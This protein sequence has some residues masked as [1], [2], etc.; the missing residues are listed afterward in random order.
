MKRAT[1]RILMLT[2]ALLPLTAVVV[3]DESAPG[4]QS[5][6]SETEMCSVDVHQVDA[7]AIQFPVQT[8]FAAAE[9]QEGSCT[10]CTTHAQCDAVCG[11]FGIC[12]RDLGTVCG[13]FPQDKYCFC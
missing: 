11:G 8:R 13:P 7:S 4:A 10:P 6:I 9:G 2:L 1:V 5:A 12:L 3:A